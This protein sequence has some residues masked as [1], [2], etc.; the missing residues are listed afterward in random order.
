MAHQSGALL[1]ALTASL[2]GACMSH[3]RSDEGDAGR[4]ADAASSD[5]AIPD[6]GT[7]AS[8]LDSCACI[9]A[10]PP[11][12]GVVSCAPMDAQAIVC[13]S[14]ICDGLDSY[15]WNGERCLPIAC[16]TCVGADCAGLPHSMEQCVAAHASCEPALCTGTGG[17][18]LF[19]AEECGHY[20]CGFPT[21]ADCIVGMP[22]CNCGAGRSFAPGG[23]C[24]T[25]TTCPE[26]DPLPPMEL[27]AATG[28]TWTAAICCSPRCGVPCAAACAADACVCSA[29]QVFDP[30]RGCVDTAECHVRPAGDE[31]ATPRG[32]RCAD[33]LLCCMRCGGAGC[34][35]ISRCQVPL[36]DADPNID[37]CGND[38]FAP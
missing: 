1:I 32:L 24:F 28:G 35:P 6:G 20:V 10:P 4:T 16:G 15:A 18:W 8:V 2:L 5:G 14:A 29:T 17:E 25:D 21:P 12:A 34:D 26:V 7:D 11:D 3:T 37:E 22:V 19:F 9:D 31:C 27:C 23:G 36:C 38:R 30:L 13:P 33:G